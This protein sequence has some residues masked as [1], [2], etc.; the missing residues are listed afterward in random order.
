MTMKPAPVG[1]IAA[2][3]EAFPLVKSQVDE[4]VTRSLDPMASI[5]ELIAA[6][7]AF[8]FTQQASH[9]F[10]RELQMVQ[11]NLLGHPNLNPRH[12]ETLIPANTYLL[13]ATQ[14]ALIDNP[15][16]PLWWL[17]D[18][19]WPLTLDSAT[20]RQ[21]TV[22]H[23]IA[24]AWLD[25]L[26]NLLSPDRKKNDFYL[27]GLCEGVGGHRGTDLWIAFRE[28]KRK[29]KYL[30]RF[31]GWLRALARGE[32]ID[33]PPSWGRAFQP[34]PPPPAPPPPPLPV[35]IPT[36]GWRTR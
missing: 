27:H 13:A 24:A 30:D 35:P 7:E 15:A 21:L 17:V 10:E 25:P 34:P 1:T 32:S 20:L 18:L 33:T 26:W 23:L 19:R 14:Q 2:W 16:V 6:Q 11:R 29:A 8:R 31:P 9:A 4:L 3:R 22:M 36:W 12:L 5:D 28:A